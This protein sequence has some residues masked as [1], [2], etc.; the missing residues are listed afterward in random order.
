MSARQRA[1][2]V[3]LIASFF[4]M[5][6]GLSSSCPAVAVIFGTI[7]VFVSAGAFIVSDDGD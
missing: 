6:I 1:G 5:D 3:A 4:M 7:G 2:L